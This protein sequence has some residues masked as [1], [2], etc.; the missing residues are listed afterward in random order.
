MDLGKTDLP[1]VV[2]EGALLLSYS[3]TG[4]SRRART[5]ILGRVMLRMT[6]NSDGARATGRSA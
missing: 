3:L 5:A 1:A 6:A 4:L 2:A